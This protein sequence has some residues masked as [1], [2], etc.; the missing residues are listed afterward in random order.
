LWSASAVPGLDTKDKQ[1]FGVGFLV[2]CCL[3][4]CALLFLAALSSGGG[5]GGGGGDAYSRMLMSRLR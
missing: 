5:G 2:I 3:C 1:L 4:C